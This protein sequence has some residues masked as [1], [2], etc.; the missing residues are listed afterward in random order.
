MLIKQLF[1]FFFFCATAEKQ[2]RYRADTCGAETRE[3]GEISPNNLRNSL[4]LIFLQ[5]TAIYFS[6]NISHSEQKIKTQEVNFE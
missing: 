5:I 6:E 2:Y 1:Q 4:D 3:F